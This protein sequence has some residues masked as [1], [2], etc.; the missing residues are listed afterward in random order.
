MY[1]YIYTSLSI[2]IFTY[3]YIY[4]F[5]YVYIYRY[6]YI[7]VYIYILCAIALLISTLTHQSL[8][9]ADLAMAAPSTACTVDQLMTTKNVRNATN[10]GSINETKQ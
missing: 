5:I 6:I 2:F 3:I 1:I 4:M 8:Q 7:Y 9:E 10:A